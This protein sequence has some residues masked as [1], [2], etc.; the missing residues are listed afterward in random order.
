V[1]RTLSEDESKRLLAGHGVPVVADR[2]VHTVDEA[3]AAADAIGYPV[4]LKLSG[5]GIAHK[6]ERGLVRLELADADDVADAAS[7]LLAAATPDD[8]EVA[9]LVAPMLRGTRELIAG[10]HSDE[11]FGRCV[12]LG[13]GGVLAEAV[14]DVSFR[15]VPIERVDAQEMLD[16]LRGRALLGAV[17]G[18]PPVDRDAVVEVL[19]GLSAFAKARPDVQSVD[20][21]PLVV[22]D[23]MPIAVDALVEVQP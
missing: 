18:E 3:R 20:V 4:V 14:A 8:G 22:V 7:D 19:L 21:N 17:R 23:G 9:L 16:D 5:A 15:L 10:I 11:Q 13:F 2:V 12:M 6:T 1:S